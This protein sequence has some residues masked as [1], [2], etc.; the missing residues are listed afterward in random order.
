MTPSSDKSPTVSI[1]TAV[2]RDRGPDSVFGLL[3]SFAPQVDDVDFEFIVVD[4]E[5]DR[6]RKVF[7]ERFPWVELIQTSKLMPVP[8]MRNFALPRVRGEI[9]GFVEDHALLPEGY[10]RNLVGVF[11]RGYRVAGGPVE[12][13]NPQSVASR[14]HHF[15]EYHNFLSTV[16]EG[17]IADLPGSNFAYH[18]DV[19]EMLGRFPEG[20]YGVETHT[21]NRMKQEGNRLHFCHGLSVHHINETNIT[22]VMSRRFTYGRLFAARRGFSVW[23][24]LAYIV[25]S[26]LVVLAEYVRIFMHVRRDRTHL[27]R[28]ARC[29]PL[30]IPTLVVWMAGECLGYLS[31]SAGENDS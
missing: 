12:N 31:G 28:F 8:Q 1:V 29:T 27:K 15:C 21:H 9:V 6:R 7:E 5:D 18:K 25:L 17:E 23:K 13:A 11:A 3:E 24:R 10:L 19:L 30:L 14:V 4:E 2:T 22:A 20:T 26:P 16:N